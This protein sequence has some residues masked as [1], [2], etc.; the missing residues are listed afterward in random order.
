MIE[1]IAYCREKQSTV[2]SGHGT[3]EIKLQKMIGVKHSAMMI[4]LRLKIKAAMKMSL[5]LIEN[6]V[7]CL[8]MEPEKM[9]ER[10]LEK[11]Q[12]LME[13]IR[14][15]INLRIPSKRLDYMSPQLI[16]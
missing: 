6:H 4:A 7:Q 8:M 3:E 15:A 12:N 13:V 10:Q 16:T 1:T 14:I 9:K 2:E 5:K 11:K